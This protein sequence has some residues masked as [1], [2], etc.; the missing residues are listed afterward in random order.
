M[1]QYCESRRYNEISRIHVTLD[2]SI[3][4]LL[5]TGNLTNKSEDHL[6]K[7]FNPC[8]CD[9]MFFFLRLYN[10]ITGNKYP[11]DNVMNI[12]GKLPF[13]L[14]KSVF[15]TAKWMFEKKLIKH[16]PTEILNNKR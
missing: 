8:S 9:T 3:L 15:L 11:I 13:T 5:L 12:C 16:K 7:L 1:N 6:I 2:F 14:K 10:I 4:L